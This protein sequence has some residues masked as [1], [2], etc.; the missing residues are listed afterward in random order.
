VEEVPVPARLRR[1]TLTGAAVQLRQPSVGDA[2][3][4]YELGHGSPAREA[5]WTYMGYGPWPARE[6]FAAWL[7]ARRRSRDPLWFTVVER[8]TTRPVGMV[9]ICNAD[10]GHRRMELGHIWYGLEAQGTAVTTEAALLLLVEAFDYYRSRRVE[11]KCDALNQR[12]RRA[13]LALGF[14]FEGIF[15]NHMIVKGRSRDTAWFAI[16]DDDW[17][18]VRPALEERLAARPPMSTRP[19]EPPTE[20][21]TE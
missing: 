12:S 9:S 21:S 8:T 11:W 20:P 18:A 14:T 2:G 17:P 13:A 6:D 10:L 19:S 7:Q 4:L 5:I 16:T 1:V 3:A 15:R